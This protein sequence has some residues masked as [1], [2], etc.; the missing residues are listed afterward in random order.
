MAFGMLGSGGHKL[1]SDFVNRPG[2]AGLFYKQLCHSVSHG[3]WKYLYGA[4]T[5]QR[6]EMVLTVINKLVFNILTDSKSWRT[7]K[8]HYWF[9]SYSNFAEKSEYFLLDKVV[10]FVGGGSV[11]NGAYPV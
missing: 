3:L 4:A 11:I 2:V 9:K 10:K 5:P 8:F 6:L 1:K 7:S